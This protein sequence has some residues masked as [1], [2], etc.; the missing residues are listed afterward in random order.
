MKILSFALAGMVLATVWGA[1]GE[2]QKEIFEKRR[3]A[4][5]KALEDG[6]GKDEKGAIRAYDE[7]VRKLL[8][9]FP[10]LPEAYDFMAFLAGSLEGEEGRA[11]AG[12]VIDSP[13]ATES[14][15][16]QA[17]LTL[18]KLDRIGKPLELKFTALDGR[19]V[20]LKELKGKVVL[21]DFWATW[22]PPCVQEMP[23]LKKVYEKYH[24]RG[25]EIIGMSIDEDRKALEKFV[26][27]QKIAWPQRFEGQ[28]WEKSPA[29]EF[30]LMSIPSVFLVDK[31]GILRYAAVVE[32]LEE[33]IEKLL[34]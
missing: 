13:V 19:R 27:K 34:N 29:A 30:G 23:H 26:A 9:D 6:V 11:L 4:L 12:R 24:P 17:K 33:K 16:G 14:A 18:R 7:G 10:N 22:C 5:N 3:E 1:E 15:K 21:I 25:F 20:D 8:G 31:E 28:P 2:G 32:G